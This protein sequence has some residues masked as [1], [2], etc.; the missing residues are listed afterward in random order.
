MYRSTLSLTSV[1]DGGWVVSAAA[2]SLYPH[3]RTG[4]H[5]IGGCVAPGLVWTVAEY[6]APTGIRSPDR[7]AVT[8]RY[9]DRAIPA[10]NRACTFIILI[11][12]F[13][14]LPKD[15][16]E[17][18]LLERPK[19]WLESYFCWTK[20]LLFF[21]QPFVASVAI[22]EGRLTSRIYASHILFF[23]VFSVSGNPDIFIGD[24]DLLCSVAAEYWHVS[25]IHYHFSTE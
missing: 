21:D 14:S 19:F 6:L 25:I 10:P 18:N 7:P 15:F 9:A 12:T 24:L 4:T 17:N 13:G 16:L 3:E 1:L 20:E 5:C 23:R 2:R 8:S 22:P 11:L